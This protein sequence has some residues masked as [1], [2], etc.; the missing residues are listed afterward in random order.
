MSGTDE[1][2]ILGGWVL[3]GAD[4]ISFILTQGVRTRDPSAG[5][6]RRRKLRVY[7]APSCK[8]RAPRPPAAPAPRTNLALLLERAIDSPGTGD[9][10]CPAVWGNEEPFFRPGQPPFHQGAREEGRF[11]FTE[12][13]EGSGR[14][15]RFPSHRR[16]CASEDRGFGLPGCFPILSWA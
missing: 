5:S 3:S 7:R 8:L 2:F 12:D 11:G 6:L 10:Q 15:S 9:V 1:R 4:E 14:V 16:G 13:P